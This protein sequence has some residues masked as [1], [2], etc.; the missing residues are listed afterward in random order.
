MGWGGGRVGDRGRLLGFKTLDFEF[1]L[2]NILEEPLLLAMLTY[3]RERERGE[4]Y[5]FSLG[6]LVLLPVLQ[7]GHDLLTDGRDVG[8]AHGWVNAHC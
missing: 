5:L 6:V 7:F 8:G 3:D 4:S 2:G 1:C